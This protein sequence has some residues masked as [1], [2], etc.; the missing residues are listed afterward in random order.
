LPPGWREIEA[1]NPH[2]IVFGENHGTRESPELVESIACALVAKGERVLVA[3]ELSSTT[4]PQLQRLW[5]TPA[6]GFSAR[7]L[8]ELPGF[9]DRPDGVASQAMLKMLDRL[10]A[11]S[12]SGK[13]IDVVAFNG[14]RDAA[15]A[16]RWKA[17]PGQGP[18]EAAQAENIATAAAAK[19]YDR[20]LVLVGIGHARKV[21]D[22]PTDIYEPMAMRLTHAGR[23]VSLKQRFTTGTAWYCTRRAAPKNSER[24][25]LPQPDCG[26]HGK[27]GIVPDRPIRVGLWSARDTEADRAY[28][29]FY[30]FP[31][32][33]ASPPAGRGVVR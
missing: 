25:S 28:D 17:L 10:H 6:E 21:Q 18:H 20:V 7:V 27:I 24:G 14:A 15:Q 31:V 9:A 26:P 23:L 2:F 29:G 4:D 16:Q 22:D 8:A 19:S 12:K 30:W 3:V 1:K 32:V 33:H 5:Q 13:P 11:L